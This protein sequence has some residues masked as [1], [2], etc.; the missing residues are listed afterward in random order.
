MRIVIIPLEIEDHD[1]QQLHF[2]LLP[3]QDAVVH[4]TPQIELYY[5]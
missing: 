5:L 1:P 2:N 3:F 4:D